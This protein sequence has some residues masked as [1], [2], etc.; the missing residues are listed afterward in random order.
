M[1][2]SK[3]LAGAAALLAIAGMPGVAAASPAVNVTPTNFVTETMEEPIKVHNDRIDLKTRDASI[4]RMQLLTFGTNSTTGWHHHPG[5][6]IVG[7]ESGSIDLWE[8][9]C[10]KTT[11]GPGSPNGTVFI[12]ALPHAHQAT[13]TAGAL[14]RVTYIVPSTGAV[15]PANFRVEEQVPFCATSF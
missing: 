10:S 1:N 14:V 6:V 11:Y 12:E 13:S 3:Q 5:M 2:Y 4:V 9:D 15:T 8:T 7:V